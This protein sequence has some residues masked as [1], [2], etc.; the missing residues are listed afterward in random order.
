MGGYGSRWL[1]CR[2]V[3][4]FLYIG[5]KIETGLKW[6]KM[7]RDHSVQIVNLQNDPVEGGQFLMG[8]DAPDATPEEQPVHAVVVP[9]FFISNYE[10]TIGQF[11]QFVRMSGYVTDAKKRDGVVCTRTRH[12]QAEC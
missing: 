11:R 10:V 3:H 6:R 12:G 4:W 1:A 5:D 8:S 2:L 7:N 9:P